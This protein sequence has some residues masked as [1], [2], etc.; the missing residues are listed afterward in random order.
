MEGGV[1]RSNEMSADCRFA[2]SW[3]QLRFRLGLRGRVEFGR[4]SWGCAAA[5]AGRRAHGLLSTKHLAADWA[6]WLVAADRMAVVDDPGD[7]M[8]VDVPAVQ[9]RGCGGDVVGQLYMINACATY[10]LN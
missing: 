3:G 4:V 8:W 6:A 2:Q 10:L 1:A 9:R 5:A 7:E